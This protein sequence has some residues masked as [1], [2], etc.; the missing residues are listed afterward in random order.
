[1]RDINVD[2]EGVL[3]VGAA[4]GAADTVTVNATDQVDVIDV[5]AVAGEIHITGLTAT[6][7]ITHADPLLDRLIVNTLGGVD[8]VNIGAGVAALIGVTVNQ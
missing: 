3:G 7:R 4:D 8:Q 6:V 1:V 2:L 5:A